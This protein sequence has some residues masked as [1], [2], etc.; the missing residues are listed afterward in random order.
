MATASEATGTDTGIFFNIQR[1]CVHDG[2]GIRT[3][4]FA[5]GCPLHC[6]WCSN[7]ESQRFEPEVAFKR[8]LCIGVKQCGLCLPACPHHAIAP[9]EEGGVAVDRARCDNCGLC[10][11]A[12]PA[13]ALV[14]LGRP[15][16]VEE[17]V[18]KV[19]EDSNFYWRS[20]GG[21]TISGGEPLAQP[22]FVGSL[23]KTLKSRNCNTVVET[24]GHFDLDSP[25]ADE[26]LRNTNTL[27]FDVKLMDPVR[28]Q[29]LTGQSNER[30]LSNL[31]ELPRR[32][33]HIAITVRTPVI[34]GVNDNEKD[35]GEIAEFLRKVAGLKDYELL[36][37]H[38]FGA[39]KYAQLGRRYAL[40]SLKPLAPER[41]GELQEHA[42]KILAQDQARRITNG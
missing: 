22:R 17:L 42:R 29:A 35:I 19:E 28:H 11:G 5:K 21:P 14:F 3:I 23:L 10:V 30:I 20:G 1:F 16:R 25:D 39:P 12:C 41:L 8:S 33:P 40:S 32:H 36:A 18:S 38:G 7:P 31:L 26:A 9:H 37:Y 15:Y 27:L 4:L 6:L 2:P 13:K 34:P 24:C